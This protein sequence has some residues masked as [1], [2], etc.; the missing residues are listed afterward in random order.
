MNASILGPRNKE[1]TSSKQA[2]T[3]KMEAVRSFELLKDFYQTARRHSQDDR[4]FHSAVRI[5]NPT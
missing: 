4:T 3:L 2:A 5:S 1:E